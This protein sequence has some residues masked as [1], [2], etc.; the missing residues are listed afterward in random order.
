M[1]LNERLLGGNPVHILVLYCY[2]CLFNFSKKN[3]HVCLLIILQVMTWGQVLLF[4]GADPLNEAR[5]EDWAKIWFFLSNSLFFFSYLN[6]IFYLVF[7]FYYS[8][9]LF[10]VYLLF[11]L[12]CFAYFVFWINL[13]FLLVLGFELSWINFSFNLFI[14]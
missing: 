3:N 4:K 8:V 9:I 7:F 2:L 6:F 12:V 10:F 1:T 11:F 5:L 13:L 14:F